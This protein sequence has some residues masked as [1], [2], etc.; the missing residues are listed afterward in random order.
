M[1]ELL[2]SSLSNF[3]YFKGS[4]PANSQLISRRPIS[5][6]AGDET[7]FEHAKRWRDTCLQEHEN[8]CPKVEPQLMPTR[9]IDV[10]PGDGSREPRL[11]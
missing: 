8:T 1:R 11:K 5:P 9:C 2:S 7:C 6:Y 10:R 4:H 3:I